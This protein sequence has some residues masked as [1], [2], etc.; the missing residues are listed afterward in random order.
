MIAKNDGGDSEP[1]NLIGPVMV[2]HLIFVDEMQDDS[3]VHFT[4]GPV[5]YRSDRP[6]QTQ[7]DI[8]RLEFRPGGELVYELP[9]SINSLRVFLFHPSSSPTC[10]IAVSTDGISFEAVE[11]ERNSSEQDAGNYGYLQPV[12]LE[13]II[14]EENARYVRLTNKSS[15]ESNED[16]FQVSRVEIVYSDESSQP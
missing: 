2:K 6:R 4:K 7:E 13:A 16:A 1:S 12:L 15:S 3:L 10:E 8:H 5:R 9:K 11:P 14:A